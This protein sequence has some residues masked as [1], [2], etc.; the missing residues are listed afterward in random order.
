LC[1]D[2]TFTSVV[3]RTRAG[4]E[5]GV[6]RCD[7]CRFHYVNPEPDAAEL[8]AFY[9]AEYRGRHAEVWHGLE[10]DANRA[11]IEL[12]RSRG[13]S[14]LVDLGAGQG[15][16]VHL[17]RQA[18]FDASGVEPVA[19]NAAEAKARYG[20]DLVHASVDAY[21]A[22][23]PGG[24]ECFTLLNVLEHVP[25]PLG[26][27]RRLR[28]ALRDGGTVL[29]IVPNVSFTF[30]LGAVRRLLGFRDVYM[31]E[32]PRFTQQGFDPPVHLS[33]FDARHL[34][35]LFETAGFEVALLRQA[36][37][38]RASSA[39]VDTAK[40]GMYAAGRILET[41]TAGATHWGYSLL[42]VANRP[43]RSSC[44]RVGQ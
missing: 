37:V 5:Y 9:D 41:L 20:I 29:A 16:F 43:A 3:S 30:T 10:D 15:R 25:D 6:V 24:V 12:L 14:S 13:V 28:E 7:A 32:S 18:G 39:L 44:R 17:A 2:E 19:A 27:V 34:R 22:R 36:P 8:S 38:I 35:Q 26:I 42:I 21:L 40:R 23:H 11:V 4:Q 1:G 31:L 33:S